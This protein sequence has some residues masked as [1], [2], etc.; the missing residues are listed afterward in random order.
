MDGMPVGQESTMTISTDAN[1]N[2]DV[3]KNYRIDESLQGSQFQI[4]VKAFA[5]D[6]IS[7]IWVTS[8]DAVS[9]LATP[10]VQPLMK[11]GQTLTVSL[12]NPVPNATKYQAE[13]VVNRRATGLSVPLAI[14]T[15][16]PSVVSGQI[17]IDNPVVA[18]PYQIQVQALAPNYLP[19][20][21]GIS[22]GIA[23]LGEPATI[24]GSLAWN[25]TPV[26]HIPVYLLD[27][28]DNQVLVGVITDNN[29][30][31]ILDSL[32]AG[33]YK[34]NVVAPADTYWQFTPITDVQTESGKTTEMGTLQLER[35]VAL[36]SPTNDA[37]VT[38]SKPDFSWNALP[39]IT[40]YRIN[41]LGGNT[42]ITNDVTGTAW[43]LT[44]DLA[45][46]IVYTW[47]VEGYNASGKRI[48]RSAQQTFTVQPGK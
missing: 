26:P 13:V 10:D 5:T 41:L 12:Q 15:G 24:T 25:S 35:V 28:D 36:V 6:F 11:S 27:A 31:F 42:N 9:R 47:S 4:R 1:G 3:R 33:T 37:T 19:S 16:T 18:V 46:G 29:G 43:Q 39:G 2:Q 14:S 30:H 22:A 44:A 17:T 34:L 8:S 45:S 21:W 48:A 40:R 38:S 23:L 32:Y 20:N 7:S